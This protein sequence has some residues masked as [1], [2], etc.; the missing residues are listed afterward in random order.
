MHRTTLSGAYSSK[1]SGSIPARFVDYPSSYGA[2]DF[3]ER[4][5]ILDPEYR[6]ICA[7]LLQTEYF[8]DEEFLKRKPILQGQFILI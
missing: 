8:N 7:E 2:K 4:C 1:G 5:L 3:I 6:P